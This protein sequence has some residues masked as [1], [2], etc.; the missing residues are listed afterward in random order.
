[1]NSL[2]TVLPTINLLVDAGF[3]LI[4]SRHEGRFVAAIHEF[5]VALSLLLVLAVTGTACSK[6][7]GR[8][9][10]GRT[11]PMLRDQRF[12]KLVLGLTWTD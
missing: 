3:G 2:G 7:I 12:P 10:E 6:S 5:V 4:I 1:M 9:P 8:R 11:R